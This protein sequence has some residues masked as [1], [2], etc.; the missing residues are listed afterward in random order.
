MTTTSIT[1][2]TDLVITRVFDAPRKLVFA[3]WTEP[4]QLTAWMGPAGF[5]AHSVTGDPVP[6]GRFRSAIHSEKYGDLWSSG[7]YREVVAPERLV[8]TWGWEEPPGTPGLQTLITITFADQDGKTEMKFLQQG[9]ADIEARDSHE[10]G[11]TS[12]FDKLSGYLQ[13]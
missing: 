12:S 3:A 11:W 1:P 8:F 5:T 9:L 2:G 6:G 10:G 4:E 7:T 13:R